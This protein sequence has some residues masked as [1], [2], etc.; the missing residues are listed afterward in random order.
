MLVLC[1]LD[2][3]CTFELLSRGKIG[4]KYYFCFVSSIDR[5]DMCYHKFVKIV[6]GTFAEGR[7]FALKLEFLDKPLF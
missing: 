7:S 4:T 3:N 2:G 6:I 1:V 5:S